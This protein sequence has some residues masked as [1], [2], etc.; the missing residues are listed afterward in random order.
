MKAQPGAN[1]KPDSD[2]KTQGRVVVYLPEELLLELTN[3]AKDHDMSRNQ[4]LLK[5]LRTHNK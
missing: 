4:Y 2:R 1:I 3:S 5:V